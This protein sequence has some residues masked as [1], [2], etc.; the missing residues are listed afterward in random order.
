MRIEFIGIGLLGVLGL[1][2]CGPN[3]ESVAPGKEVAC[4]SGTVNGGSSIITMDCNTVVQYEG[5]EFQA[6]LA[7]K[8]W[9][10]AGLSSAPKVL[11]EVDNA[12]TD[13][14]VQ[15]TQTCRAYN[16]CQ[17]RADEFNQELARTQEQFRSLREKVSLLQASGGNPE[18]LRSTIT[19]VYRTTVPEQKRVESTLAVNFTVQAKDP[20]G[21]GGRIVKEGESLATGT[22]IVFGVEV[23]QT[24]HVYVFERHESGVIDV[25]FP[26]SGIQ[27]LKNPLNPGALVRIPSGGQ[28]F[29]LN[30]EDMGDERIYVAVSLQPLSDLNAALSKANSGSPQASEVAPAMDDLFEQSKPECTGKRGFDLKP[31]DS[32]GTL[33]RGLDLSP[34][35]PDPFF[36]N[37]GSVRV[38][39]TPGDEVIVKSFLFKHVP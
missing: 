28:V 31:E 20:G 34:S 38:A 22:Q 10:E 18:V 24:A 23:S 11:R 16:S 35:E 12:A 5:N 32:C 4:P 3:K 27:D 6:S 30:D 14:Q 19:E 37:P 39:A 2:G 33:A 17:V 36:K 9:A 26:N 7:V 1:M 25:L 29:T 13:A 21:S 8:Q 15:F